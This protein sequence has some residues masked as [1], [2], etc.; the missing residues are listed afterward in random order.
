MSIP[1]YPEFYP[2][3]LKHTDDPKTTDDLLKIISPEMGISEEDLA[4]RHPSG[5]KKVRN[6][7]GWGIW[8]LRSRY[9][10]IE[11]VSRG[12][13]VITKKGK[14][15]RQKYGMNITKRILEEEL[16]NNHDDTGEEEL[17][18]TDMIETATSKLRMEVKKVLLENIL[19]KDPYFF[20]ELVVK[21]LKKMGYGTEENLAET[22]GKSGDEGI[23]GIIY[24]DKLGF[25]AIYI[26]AKKWKDKTPVAR[27]ELQKFAGALLGKKAQKGVFITTSSFSGPAKNYARQ[28]KIRCI[29]GQALADLMIDYEV[30]TKVTHRF[31]VY[32]IDEDFFSE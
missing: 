17:T 21:L 25:D 23:D 16:K 13:Y 12:V 18:P 24:Q 5:E 28:Q 6:R 30:G 27:D 3:I 10:L 7:L 26:Q 9:G 11:T 14:K 29:D 1:K 2:Y 4:V 32:E 19:E 15:V 20:E 22:T 31:N 8:D